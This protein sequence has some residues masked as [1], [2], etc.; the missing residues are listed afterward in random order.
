MY[1]LRAQT[2]SFCRGEKQ[3][4]ELPRDPESRTRP[5]KQL[6]AQNVRHNT[7]AHRRE[8]CGLF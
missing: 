5:E 1:K 7:A 2:L 6:F 3:N 8:L 4:G